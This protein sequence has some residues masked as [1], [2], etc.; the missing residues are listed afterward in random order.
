MR[1]ANNFWIVRK[2]HKNFMKFV[3]GKVGFKGL[4]I[5]LYLS[6]VCLN[7]LIGKYKC[8]ENTFHVS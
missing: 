3:D 1:L 6:L 8:F 4:K 2:T 7:I 5:F